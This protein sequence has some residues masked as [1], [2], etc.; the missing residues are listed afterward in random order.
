M[1]QKGGLG[2]AKADTPETA[3]TESAVVVAGPSAPERRDTARRSID[4]MSD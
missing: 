1:A 4:I 2:G 3:S